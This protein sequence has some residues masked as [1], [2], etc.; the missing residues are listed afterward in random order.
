LSSR[1]ES[2]RVT[3]KFLSPRKGKSKRTSTS[4]PLLIAAALLVGVI[5]AFARP[6]PMI[7]ALPVSLLTL[8]L[9]LLVISGLPIELVAYFL[10]S[11][12]VNDRPPA[13]RTTKSM[14]WLIRADVQSE[15]KRRSA[16]K[17][18]VLVAM[19]LIGAVRPAG[20]PTTPHAMA[21]GRGVF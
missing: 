10:R 15:A 21:T 13:R 17:G 18:D 2:A 12:V 20:W 9:F 19:S 14:R 1:A 3:L 6:V 8:G 11:Y 7:P 16:R 4:R 5:I